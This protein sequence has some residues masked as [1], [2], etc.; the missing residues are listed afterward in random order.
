MAGSRAA[1]APS[2]IRRSYTM[3]LL[4]PAVPPPLTHPKPESINGAGRGAFNRAGRSRS[5]DGTGR[6]SA[7][8]GV[9]LTSH[10]SLLWQ[11][12]RT[13]LSRVRQASERTLRA[14]R[15]RKISAPPRR[16]R[17]GRPRLA[18]FRRF[19]HRSFRSALA[20]RRRAPRVAVLRTALGQRSPL[21]RLAHGCAARF[22]GV[23]TR[24]AP[25]SQRNASCARSK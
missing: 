15:L 11:A 19:S 14:D 20:G 21:T 22:C 1:L 23:P 2:R 3:Q 13:R 8:F 16:R 7:G 4:P 9:S 17:W 6:F 12:H 18:R 10:N 5:T 24:M 25:R